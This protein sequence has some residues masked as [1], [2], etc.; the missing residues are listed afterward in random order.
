MRRPR[1]RP[2]RRS[3]A[4]LAAEDPSSWKLP[5]VDK[6]IAEFQHGWGP[7]YAWVQ[8]SSTLYIFS[9]LQ[10][11]ALDDAGEK[12]PP[13]VDLSL[14]KEG[15]IIR[16]T[17]EG[18]EILSGPLA[19]SLRVGDQI[20]M[21]EDAPDGRP[22][23][24]CELDKLLPGIDWLS[25][26]KPKVEVVADYAK[27]VVEMLELLTEQEAATVD[28]TLEHLRQEKR[29]LL[30]APEGKAAELGDVLRVDMQGYEL[31]AD[32]SR[33]EPLEIGSAKDLS[34][35]LG[36]AGFS[37]EV[38]QS[39]IGM[40][41]GETR[42]VQVAL[43]KNAGDM[44]GQKIICAVTCN[45]LKVMQLPALDDDF[46]RLIKREEQFKQAGTVEGIPEEEEG[47]AE[48]FTLANL[49]SEI[50]SE[51]QRVAGS[52]AS[53]NID[54]QLQSHLRQAM[55]VSCHWG[56][57]SQEARA[58]E[59]LAAITRSLAEKEGLMSTIDM[60]EICRQT[61]DKVAE[62]NEGE[63]VKEVGKDPDRDYQAAHKSVLNKRV[64]DEV[65][66]WLRQRMELVEAGDGQ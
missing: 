4:R 53:S 64:M 26:M 11:V 57:L 49:R 47:I 58:A 43:G 7:S 24:V 51:V 56:D 21:V 28:E 33:G 2:L 37:R 45:E 46:A 54:Q 9:P 65:M 66:S 35:E 48:A 55:K 50:A 34:L 3:I 27:P 1:H 12:V 19:H 10:K 44:N 8:T 20:W 15:S 14:E 36:A 61:W 31:A 32:G 38:Q 18:S 23:V 59:E 42:D 52:Q 63:T 29:V 22:F 40:T 6:D 39:L 5:T 62:P 30:E 17:V 13:E 60:D 25:V 16:L 41:A